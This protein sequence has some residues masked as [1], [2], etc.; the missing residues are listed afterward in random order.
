MHE[1]LVYI[2]QVMEPD[3]ML[4]LLGSDPLNDA[5]IGARYYTATGDSGQGNPWLPAVSCDVI[6][7]MTFSLLKSVNLRT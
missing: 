3:D 1:H 7:C 5:Q 6:S 4:H 2:V